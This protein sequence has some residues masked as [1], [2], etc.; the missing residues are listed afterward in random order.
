MLEAG[1]A[2]TKGAGAEDAAMAM[3]RRVDAAEMARDS[4]W[5]RT[6]LYSG[7]VGTA[8][9][10]SSLHGLGF[11]VLGRLRYFLFSN[12]FSDRKCR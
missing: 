1:D 5:Y 6:V 9:G 11:I 4:A 10:V 2:D 3:K 8:R 12:R 7:V